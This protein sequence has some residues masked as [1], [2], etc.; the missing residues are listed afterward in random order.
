MPLL[1]PQ[2]RASFLREYANGSYG[3]GLYYWAKSLSELPFNILFPIIF[4]T[5]SYW[6]VGLRVDAGA[7]F[8]NMAA[9]I[10]VSNVAQSVGLIVSVGLDIEQA[11][12]LFPVVNIPAM[13]VGGLFLLV[14][15]IPNWF[16]WLKFLSWFFYCF[17]A[18]LINEFQDST[19][20]CT[21][22]QLVDGVCPLTTGESV[23]NAYGFS[24]YEI[25]IGF[26]GMVGLYFLIRL[27]ALFALW[28]LAKRRSAT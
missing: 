10:V 12:T 21:S 4:G 3:V 25:W 5:I 24:S 6:L 19:F 22:G 8:T 13:L 20:D 9:I 7:F 18:L 11:I 23:I 2:E 26:L 16:I 17:M 14:T 27:L 15:D 28:V 1:V